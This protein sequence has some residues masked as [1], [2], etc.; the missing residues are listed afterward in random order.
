VPT[1]GVQ[2]DDPAM[3]VVDDATMVVKEAPSSSTIKL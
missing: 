2:V 3:S 1:N